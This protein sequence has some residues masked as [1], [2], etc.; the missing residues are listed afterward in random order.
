MEKMREI[1]GKWWECS[2][3]QTI[4]QGGMVNEELVRG[5]VRREYLLECGH[6]VP[7][8][9]MLR[10]V[11]DQ[12]VH[13]PVGELFVTAEVMNKD[14][15]LTQRL[16]QRGH[17]YLP[18]FLALLNIPMGQLYASNPTVNNIGNVTETIN[19]ATFFTGLGIVGSDFSATYPN[20][21]GF[22]LG[23]GSTANS[24]TTYF[25]ASYITYGGSAGQLQYGA[26][27]LLTAAGAT[28]ATGN[29]IYTVTNGSA[30]QLYSVLYVLNVSGGSIGVNETG[31]AAGVQQGGTVPYTVQV[32]RDVLGATVNVGNL[33]SALFQY[34]WSITTS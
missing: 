24:T 19:N 17:S 30:S 25:M 6:R 1:L 29:T 21:L 12:I 32:I 26:H 34:I 10:D 11:T 3:C 22:E 23:T 16:Y 27:P 2:H 28:A 31:M 18:W 4:S 13:K 15:A 20:G 33:S 8:L 14:G 5:R 7:R 9:G